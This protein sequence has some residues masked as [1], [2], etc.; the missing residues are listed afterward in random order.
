MKVIVTGG[1]GY[2]GKN[3]VWK[4]LE[5]GHQ[6]VIIDDGSNSSQRDTMQ[7]VKFLNLYYHAIADHPKVEF[8]A[9]GVSHLVTC[10]HI[11]GADAL[12]HLAAKKSVVESVSRPDFYWSENVENTYKLARAAAG[13]KIGIMI[14]SSSASVY[15]E[16]PKAATESSPT[17]PSSPYGQ[18]K[19]ASEYAT[20]AI[21]MISPMKVRGLRYFNVVGAG[22]ENTLGDTGRERSST[23][24]GRILKSVHGCTLPI[25]IR[26]NDHET[27]DGYAY[28]DFI[29]VEDL[30][31]AH[32]AML[33]TPSDAPQY[34]VYN[35]SRGCPVSVKATVDEFVRQGVAIDC[36]VVPRNA[37][38]ISFS[39]GDPSKILADY[40]WK[41]AHDL[42]SCVK[43]AIQ[44]EKTLVFSPNP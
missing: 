30:A 35:V 11:I 20:Q 4:L 37:A 9:M 18:S 33:S 23:L 26:G 43:S 13:A 17:I 3:I 40:G 39:A 41:A 6:V 22:R 21:S 15:G 29:H 2:I 5:A 27:P 24:F 32:I 16:S 44:F 38:E 8:M 25:E 1:G 19:L 34:G 28:R 36:T 7:F 10:I 31:N 14:Y 42:E 12:I